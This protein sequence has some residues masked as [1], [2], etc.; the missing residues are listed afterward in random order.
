MFKSPAILSHQRSPSTALG[1]AVGATVAFA[2]TELAHFTPEPVDIRIEL[3][4]P[5][6]FVLS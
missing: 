6:L 3:A 4:A 1:G 2:S 5:T